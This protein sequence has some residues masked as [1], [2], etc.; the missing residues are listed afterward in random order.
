MLIS[1]SCSGERAVFA[2]GF[3]QGLELVLAVAPRLSRADGD[4][5]RRGPPGSLTG[6]MCKS[7]SRSPRQCNCVITTAV[8]RLLLFGTA[9]GRCGTGR[10][11][12]SSARGEPSGFDR[13]RGRAMVRR[14]RSR[15][16]GWTS[17]CAGRNRRERR[18]RAGCRECARTGASRG[19]PVCC[20]VGGIDENG[21]KRHA[22]EI[23]CPAG[24]DAAR[25]HSPSAIKPRN[26]SVSS[27]PAS[28]RT[29]MR[30]RCATDTSSLSGGRA[31]SHYKIVS[32]SA[33][34]AASSYFS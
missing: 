17:G 27:G 6:V 15:R 32:D 11:L 1:A 16:S 9:S 19:W 34:A 12:D 33:Q 25:T 24:C 14:T 5:Q 23:E 13:S 30:G 29:R 2:S 22:Q 8:I 28:P 3:V 26:R 10:F 7:M 18:H 31:A 21:V 20:I 4:Q